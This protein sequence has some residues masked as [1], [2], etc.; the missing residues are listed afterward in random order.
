MRPIRVR[1]TLVLI[2]LLLA[3]KLAPA[4]N[5]ASARSCDRECLR[6]MLTSYLNALVAHNPKT[7]PLAANVRFTENTVEKPLGEGLWKTASGLGSFRQDILD[8]RQG[9]AGTHVVI[10]NSG[11]P[12]LLQVRLKLADGRISDIDTTVVRNK[13]EGMIFLPEGFESSEPCYEPYTR[14]FATQHARRNDQA[15]TFVS[16]RPES[17]QFR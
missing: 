1:S 6:G 4:Q 15:C 16:R 14:A 11:A 2:G 10:E 8:V 7:L 12:A 17:R 9:V 3:V 5:S 13:D